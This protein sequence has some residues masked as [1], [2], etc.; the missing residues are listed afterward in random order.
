MPLP[1][2]EAPHRSKRWGSGQSSV[3]TARKHQCF[4]RG[5]S[6]ADLAL[7]DDVGFAPQ[8]RSLEVQ[9]D[10]PESGHQTTGASSNAPVRPAFSPKPGATILCFD[11]PGK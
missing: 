1:P 9:H 3:M 7:A 11:P 6:R 2:S 4:V 5:G 10:I 8:Y